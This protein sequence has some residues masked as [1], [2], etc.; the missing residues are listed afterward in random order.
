MGVCA[1]ASVC[2][3]LRRLH[4][5]SG[6]FQ[7]ITCPQTKVKKNTK[8]YKLIF[9]KRTKRYD[10]HEACE[11]WNASVMG[12]DHPSST[13]QQW[14]R[15]VQTRV[16]AGSISLQPKLG[17]RPNFLCTPEAAKQ[18]AS[19]CLRSICNVLF[20]TTSMF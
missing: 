5:H 18:S 12:Q 11:S 13:V 17:S 6:C 3:G 4:F 15:C 14:F 2:C 10:F 8:K 1:R 19:S 20:N 7:V 16:G 9:A